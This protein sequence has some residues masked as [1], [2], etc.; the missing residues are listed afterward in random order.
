M[1]ILIDYEGYTF[2]FFINKR[3]QRAL[4]RSPESEDFSEFPFFSLLYIQQATPGG[5]KFEVMFKK[6]FS[7]I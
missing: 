6:E 2:V 3:A 4:E 5:S 1:T 7:K